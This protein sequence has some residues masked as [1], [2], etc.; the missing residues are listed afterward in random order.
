MAACVWIHNTLGRPFVLIPCLSC[1]FLERGEAAGADPGGAHQSGG[2]PE[3]LLGQFY[4]QA[5]E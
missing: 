1:L 3:E 5:G 4:L 2:R